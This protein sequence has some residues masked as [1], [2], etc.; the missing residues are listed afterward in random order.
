LAALAAIAPTFAVKGNWDAWFFR[1]IDR[2]GG[3]GATE[4]DGTAAHVDVAGARVHVVG[5]AHDN[6]AAF[7]RAL[8]GVPADGPLVLLNHC[9][10]PDVIPAAQAARVDLMCAGHVHGG[11]VAL[12]FY[13]AILTISRLGKRYERGL[14]RLEAGPWLY[15][16]RGTGME[17]GAVP[18]I[19]FC[20][21]PEI[22]LIEL[23][24]AGR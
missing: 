16:S 18:R 14:Y 13:G 19:R 5:A 11:Q 7:A 15:V 20:S 22:A 1:H 10:Y 2:F 23:V 24:P 12:P 6:D 9:P 4:L 3:T 17:G 21:R 8:A